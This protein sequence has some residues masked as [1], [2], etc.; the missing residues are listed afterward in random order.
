MPAK[1]LRLHQEEAV[2]A[3]L[4]AK[5]GKVVLPT[6]TG[7]TVVE[8][9]VILRTIVKKAKSGDAGVFV[10]FAPRIILTF[11]LLRE[12]GQHL[13]F[14][15]ID[16][17]YLNVNTGEFNNEELTKLMFQMGLQPEKIT[18]TTSAA[19]IARKMT[20]AQQ[21]KRPLI[22]A[23]TYH[24]AYQIDNAQSLCDI[25]IETFTYDESQ[26]CVERGDFSETPKYRG[27]QKYFYTATPKDTNASDG[28]GMNN[29]ELFGK[30]LYRKSP[31]EMI[32]A[33]EMVGP[34]IHLVGVRGFSEYFIRR[35]EGAGPIG[36][37]R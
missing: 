36:G 8:A 30:V 26:Y 24:S 27:N 16:P 22:I 2:Q 11:Q 7:K 33:G 28:I 20:Q 10:I 13:A 18:S 4:K 31:R 1:I 23:S 29:E 25:D 3:I 17:I 34:A 15:G 35:A 6:G 9:E 5:K 32:E 12:I 14:N 37:S 19:E 21:L